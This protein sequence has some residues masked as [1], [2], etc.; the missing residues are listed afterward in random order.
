MSARQIKGSPKKRFA[1]G[2]EVR[3]KM[4]GVNGT[5]TR[6]DPS[7]TVM[8]EYWHAVRTEHGERKE[9]GSN[10]ELIPIPVTN[11]KSKELTT[12]VA[13]AKLS[14]PEAITLLRVQLQEA[15]ETL[16]HNDPDV[17]GW[18]RV[19][20]AIVE[21][22]FGEHSRNAKHFAVTLSKA[23]QSD[24]EAQK[25]HIENIKT[26]KGMVRAFIKELE[27]LS[28]HRPHL[29]D[30]RFMRMAVDQ[31]RMSA[32]ED[33]RA[34]PMV[35]CV[36]VK[37]GKVIATAHRGEIKG[38]HA[39]FIALEE[40]LRDEA[41]TGCTVYT[42]L[43]PCTARNHPKIPC[44]NR[45]IERRVARVV[46]GM[47]DP[48]PEICGKGIRKLQGADIE[49]TLFPHALIKELEELNRH[50][51]RSFAD[52]S[53]E[54]RKPSNLQTRGFIATEARDGSARFRAPDRPLGM[55]W[56]MMPFS[57]G[58]DYEVFL[59]NG[60]AMWLRLI[61]R[62]FT[63]KEWDHDEL[64]RCGRGPGVTL[65]PLSWSSLQ[66]MRAEDGIG[67]YATIDNLK[68]ETETSSVAFAFNTGEVW[69]IDTGVLRMTG[70][71]NLY[72]LDI[73]RTLIQRLRGYGE[74]MQCLGIQPPFDWIAGLEG[75]KGRRLKFPPPPN[76]ISTSPGQ[77]CLSDVVI[78]TGTYDPE[79]P[80]PMSLRPFFSQ[81]FKKCSSK[82]PEHIEDAIRTNREF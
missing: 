66:Y 60:P 57:Q 34:H 3:V 55:F 77:T 52:G 72:F 70:Q 25:W 19:T 82:I 23:R 24:E 63:S 4:P 81:I 30:D 46:I 13:D 20:L 54:G 74:F 18:E 16:R 79:H 64:M 9:P 26:K 39:E 35:G 61:P 75:V 59:A 58:P 65:Q 7:P 51:T 29:E 45:L 56:N 10:L 31:A 17:D 69:C 68:R 6:S 76:H 33:E 8:G 44:A 53:S 38:R 14:S 73:A 40:K 42:T 41:L 47:H 12:A 28:P 27:I 1:V 67:A 36:V 11:E 50:F 2:A 48:N 32:A 21:A 80:A 37:D 78:A 15:V 71:S 43:E 22:A 49:V 62:E 5:I